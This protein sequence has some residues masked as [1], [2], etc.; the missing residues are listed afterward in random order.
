MEELEEEEE[1]EETEERPLENGSAGGASFDRVRSF[2]KKLFDFGEREI[3][4]LIDGPNLLR[5][6][7]GKHV[8]LEAL[9]QKAEELG[10]ITQGKAV[11]SKNTPAS[12]L[13]ALTN[14]G[15]ETIVSSGNVHIRMAVEL[16]KIL[17][18]NKV[19]V[20]V[21]A[22]RDAVCVPL[23]QMA[24]KQGAKTIALGF[25]PGFSSALLN[26]ADENIVLELQKA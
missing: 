12:L 21:I 25:N 3:T 13:K 16:V 11:V 24:K 14:S 5:R 26:T 1:T 22:S 20:V 2:V 18:E 17:Q 7:K 9:R 15:F 8:S 19:D 6:V 23:I 10:R 4:I